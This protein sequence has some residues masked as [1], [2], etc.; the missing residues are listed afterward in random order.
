MSTVLRAPT[1]PY[2]AALMR[3]RITLKS[4]RLQTLA[5]LPGEPPDM[6]S[7][8]PGCPFAPRC[9]F[10]IDACTEAPPPLTRSG[11]DAVRGLHPRGRAPGHA[12]RAD[13]GRDQASVRARGAQAGGCRGG[14]AAGPRW[15]LERGS[16]RGADLGTREGLQTSRCG[17]QGQGARS[18]RDRSRGG[19]RRVHRAGRR[20]RIGKS[21]LLRTVAGLAK[22]D[23]GDGRDRGRRAP[24][25]GLSG[26]GGLADSV[27]ERRRPDR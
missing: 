4:D 18:A 10:V 20:E 13:A 14:A 15:E 2:T 7:P 26:R 11:P 24:A 19:C 16:A 25:D 22:P 27:D 17:A 9:E 5:T 12:R 1:H 21:T 6:R 3:S 8:P 23:V